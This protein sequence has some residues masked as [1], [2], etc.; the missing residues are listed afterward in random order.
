MTFTRTGDVDVTSLP[1]PATQPPRVVSPA[2]ALHGHYHLTVTYTNGE[3]HRERPSCPYGLSSHRR[4]V[5]EL[6][7]RTR[8]M[9]AGIRRREWTGTQDTVHV[10]AGGNAQM[11]DTAEYP[12]PN[13]RRIRSRCSPGTV[14]DEATGSACVGGD[15]DDK[16]VR[17]GD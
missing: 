15:F 12:L 9:A 10:P 1:D 14:T 13:R 2:E 4:S 5:H 8:G 7:P 16:F 17:T 11:K 6:F 3:Q